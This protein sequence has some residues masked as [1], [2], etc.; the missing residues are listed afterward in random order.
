MAVFHHILFPVDL[1]DRSHLV[2]PFVRMMT[3]RCK[4][5]LTVLHVIE[6][7]VFI[8][9]TISPHTTMDLPA[10]RN[11]AREQV[12]AFVRAELE[13]VP[14][15]IVI[16]EG[17]PAGRITKYASEHGV[18]LIMMPTHGHGVFRGSLLGSTTAKVVHDASCPVWTDAHVE[19]PFASEQAECRKILCAIDL[20]EKNVPL[21]RNAANL[22]AELGAAL[23]LVHAIPEMRP[24]PESHFDLEYQTIPIRDGN[25]RG[26]RHAGGSRNGRR[27]LHCGGKCGASCSIRRG[28]PS[29]RPSRDWP[30]RYPRTAGET[31]HQHI[32]GHS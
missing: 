16:Q 8:Y 2:A 29:C 14:C 32:R 20:N 12:E 9:P 10:M 17:H 24:H 31:A 30:R 28:G 22:T 6:L 27:G 5:E 19:I 18:S 7:P 21:I 15:R 1:S 25:R 4:A 26:A 11:A 23:R 13:N 3:Q